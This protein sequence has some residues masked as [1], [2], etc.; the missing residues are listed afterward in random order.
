MNTTATATHAGF[1]LKVGTTATVHNSD[2]RY[3]AGS[4]ANDDLTWI[5]VPT[6]SVAFHGKAIT[7]TDSPVTC[8]SCIKATR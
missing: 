2:A 5:A 6:C 4:K 3:L 7:P 8:K 1:N